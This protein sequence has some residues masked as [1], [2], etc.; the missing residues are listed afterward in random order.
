[1]KTRL[2]KLH[3]HN[4]EF[5]WTAKVHHVKGRDCH[6]C[7]RLRVWG[8]GKNSRLLQ[9]DLLSRAVLPWGCAT[10]DGYPTPKDVRAVIDYALANGWDPDLPSGTFYLTEAD[11]TLEL[12][13]FILTDRPRDPDSPDPTTRVLDAWDKAQNP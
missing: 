12:P 10:D 8:A 7:V 3:A 6:S 13:G 4:R 1:M 11:H 5:A 9:A 2:R